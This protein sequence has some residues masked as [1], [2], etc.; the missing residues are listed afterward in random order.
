MEVNWRRAIAD[1]DRRVLARALTAIENDTDR[2]REITRAIQPLLGKARVIGLTGPPG[3]GKSTLVGACIAEF[4]NR[5]LSVGVIAID[6][7]SPIGGGALLGD[8]VRMKT[9]SEDPKVFIRSLASRGHLGGLSQA[10]GA[11]VEV[12]DAAGMDVILVET[13]GT[14][15]SE[16][17]I[18]KL[19][20][21][22]VVVMQPGTGDDIQ[23][24]KAGV[25]EIADLLVLNKADQLGADRSVLDLRQMLALRTRGNKEIPICK[26]VAI[27]GK[28]IGDLVEQLLA[29]DTR[30]PFPG[31]QDLSMIRSQLAQATSERLSAWL[32]SEAETEVMTLCEQIRS[33][34][35]SIDQ[36][37]DALAAKVTDS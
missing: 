16:V 8:R 37:A 31:S 11:A 7:S 10:T 13:V 20:Q 25:V 4:R 18:A 30:K 19:A 22:Q 9:A 32:L 21:V 23:A 35:I 12:L 5:G 34:T 28:G 14:G 1:G 29:A 27:S 26:T 33:R 36:A 24:L 15:Q 6:P 2:A 17:E 3:V